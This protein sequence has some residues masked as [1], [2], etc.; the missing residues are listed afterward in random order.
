MCTNLVP[1]PCLSIWGEGGCKVETLNRNVRVCAPFSQIREAHYCVKLSSKFLLKALWT[2]KKHVVFV[3]WATHMPKDM[4]ELCTSSLMQLALWNN[5]CHQFWTISL[6]TNFCLDTLQRSLCII[7]LQYLSAC[8]F[9]ENFS[10]QFKAPIL[11][12]L[13]AT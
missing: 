3:L 13:L 7:P 5:S 9:E 6:P 12:I 4:Q 8:L 1:E 2:L 11:T 10:K